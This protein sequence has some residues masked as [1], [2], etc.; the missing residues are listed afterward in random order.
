[1]AS[2]IL[3]TG[4]LGGLGSELARECARRGYNLYLTD[5][6][7]DASQIV[8]SLSAEFGLKVRYRPCELTD[9]GERTALI[10]SLKAEGCQFH[11]LINVAGRDYEGAFLEQ[12]REQL[13][14]LIHLLIEAMVDL[15][16]QILNLRDPTRRFMLINISSLAGYYPMPYKATYSAAKGFIQQFSRALREE[17]RPFGNVLVVSPAGLPTHEESRRKIAAQGL[18][19]KLTVMNPRTVARRTIQRALQGKADYVPGIINQILANLAGLIPDNIITAFISRRW[20]AIQK[21]V[22]SRIGADE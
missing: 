1:M 15:S 12:S 11:G 16:H 10:E 22:F 6:P 9:L 13:L 3:I 5:R 14:Y 21:V 8:S 20:R 19:G 4:A 7:A 18:W 2:Y 17:I